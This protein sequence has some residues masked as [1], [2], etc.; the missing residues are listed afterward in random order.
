ME[1]NQDEHIDHVITQENYEFSTREEIEAQFEFHKQEVEREKAEQE[2]I[3]MIR[4][5]QDLKLQEAQ[6]I[7]QAVNL[8]KY[9][10]S[11]KQGNNSVGSS[12]Q[13]KVPQN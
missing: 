7:A 5:I 6:I 11:H 1:G 12:Y 9:V 8:S 4:L 10:S 3:Q 13:P 2:R